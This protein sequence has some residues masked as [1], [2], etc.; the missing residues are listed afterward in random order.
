ML[1]LGRMS[2]LNVWTTRTA[3]PE[4][5][6][7]ALMEFVFHVWMTPIVLGT[8]AKS[9]QQIQSK[10]NVFLAWMTVNVPLILWTRCA[11]VQPIRV[12][13]VE[14]RLTVHQVVFATPLS[15]SLAATH[16]P[17]VI[18]LPQF[19]TYK[20]KRVSSAHQLTPLSAL[21]PRQHARQTQGPVS[22][23]QMILS[24]L[25]TEA[26]AIWVIINVIIAW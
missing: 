7:W 20:W 24:V 21:G 15:A 5:L 22:L 16:W 1:Q 11:T 3:P 8:I 10:I 19:V 26:T 6:A 25:R 12:L 13:G 4:I 17:L 18:P 14:H 23:A 2:A 9:M